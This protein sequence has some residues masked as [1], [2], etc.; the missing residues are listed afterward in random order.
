MLVATHSLEF[1]RKIASQVAVLVDGRVIECGP[2]EQ[3]FD[4]PQ[5]PETRTLLRNAAGG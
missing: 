4:H 2:P 5:R 1:A 3:V